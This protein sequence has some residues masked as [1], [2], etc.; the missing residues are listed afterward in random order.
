[1]HNFVSQLDQNLRD[2]M[3][4]NGNKFVIKNELVAATDKGLIDFTRPP[5]V[6]GFKMLRDFSKYWNS[7]FNSTDRETCLDLFLG[8]R[9]AMT[10][11][12]NSDKARIDQYE[13]L[14][15]DYGLMTLPAVTRENNPQ[16]SGRPLNNG[17]RIVSGYA[18]TR[19]SG[20]PQL[21]AAADFMMYLL[22]PE[23]LTLKMDELSQLPPLTDMPLSDQARGW[24]TAPQ[25]DILYANY[26]GYATSKEFTDF[27]VLSSQI[28]L[29]DRSM[30]PESYGAQLNVEWKKMV[31]AAKIENNW[32]A[33]NNYGI[34]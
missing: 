14:D 4:L 1:M 34:K 18:L 19:Y 27:Q 12:L 30:T 11:L 10:N 16:G 7:D 24:L 33:A 29:T 20:A 9:A 8:K 26:F 6:D 13:G 17:G 28:F 21:A 31:E 25:E 5:F 3:D 23:P 2:L 15:I 22:S 32:N